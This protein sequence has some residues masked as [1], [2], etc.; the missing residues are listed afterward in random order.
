[1]LAAL[2]VCRLG[3]ALDSA[4]T[5]WLA[6][7]VVAVVVLAAAL[8]RVAAAVAAL[9]QILGVARQRKLLHANPINDPGP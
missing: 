4:R 2:V 5:P 7:E 6:Y 3:I 9:D 8:V 1:M